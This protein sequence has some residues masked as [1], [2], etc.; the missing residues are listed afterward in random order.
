MKRQIYSWPLVAAL[1]LPLLAVAPAWAVTL[2]PRGTAAY[3]EG[4]FESVD[5][6]PGVAGDGWA[7]GWITRKDATATTVTGTLTNTSPLDAGTNNYA[8]ILMTSSAANSYSTLGRKYDALAVNPALDYTINALF[9][10]EEY[11]DPDFGT[12]HTTSADRYEIYQGTS[13][14]ALAA[15]FGSAGTWCI[16]AYGADSLAGDGVTT[17]PAGNWTLKDYTGGSVYQ[18]DTG[19]SLVQGVTYAVQVTVRPDYT[20]DATISDGVTTFNKNNMRT[21]NLTASGGYVE[22]F[23]KA[24]NAGETREFSVDSVVVNQAGFNTVGG[25]NLVTAKFDGGNSTTEIDGYTGVAGNGWSDGWKKTTKNTTLTATVVS[26]GDAE[27]DDLKTGTGAYLSLTSESTAGTEWYS[28]IARDYGCINVDGIDWTQA[29][30]VQFKIRLDEDVDSELS[31]FTGNND[32]YSITDNTATAGTTHPNNTWAINSFGAESVSTGGNVTEEMVGKWCFTDGDNA[33]TVVNLINSGIALTTGGVYEF[34][35]DL[36]PTTRT[37]D[38]S[39]FDGIS[40]G[41]ATDLHWRS[42]AL[43]VGGFLNFAF[44]A[45]SVGETRAWSIDEIVISQGLTA[46][47]GDATGNGSVDEDDAKRLAE[48]WGAMGVVP[49]YESLWEMGD[50]NDDGRID[51]KDASIL[52]ANWGY[53]AGSAAESNGA[54]AVPEPGATALLLTLLGGVAIGFGRRRFVA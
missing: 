8:N 27:F 53:V 48:N 50:F 28:G 22:F 34:T 41:S 52:A 38:V 5:T 45:D 11:L 42:A 51:A 19:I 37:Y 21:R 17:I 49:P 30:T 35:V 18:W 46:I 9:R 43:N 14:T 40:T 10:V 31:T 33:G 4:G 36:D 16:G 29:H 7:A 47:P 24:S 32:R 54:T 20:W 25:M 39:V 44:C 13:A 6:Y 3:F 23:G 26:P 15:G 12:F 1:L 2:I